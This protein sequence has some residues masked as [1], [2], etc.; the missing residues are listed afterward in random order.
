[1]LSGDVRHLS[2][3]LP[4]VR[5]QTPRLRHAKKRGQHDHGKKI[6]NAAFCPQTS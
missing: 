5:A 2:A 6:S 3:L 1:M 4:H